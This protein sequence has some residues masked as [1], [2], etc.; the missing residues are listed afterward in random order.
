MGV[1]SAIYPHRLGSFGTMW[2][3]LAVG[4]ALTFFVLDLRPRAPHQSE[5]VKQSARTTPTPVSE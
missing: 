4:W 5:G 2:G 1:E 3:W